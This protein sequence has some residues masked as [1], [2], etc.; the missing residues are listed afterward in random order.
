MCK[1]RERSG[2]TP[3]EIELARHTVDSVRLMTPLYAPMN[4]TPVV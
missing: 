1:K 3:R 4:E 2:M